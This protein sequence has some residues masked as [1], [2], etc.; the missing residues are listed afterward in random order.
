MA[1]IPAFRA[2]IGAVVCS[3]QRAGMMC[4]DGKIQSSRP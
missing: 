2:E 3:R 1:P 4:A